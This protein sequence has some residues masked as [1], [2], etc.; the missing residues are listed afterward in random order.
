MHILQASSEVYPF[1]KTGGLADMVGALGKA[2]AAKGE[3]VSMVTPLYASVRKRF[4]ELQEEPEL[5]FKL[6]LGQDT[7]YAGLRSIEVNSRLT[8]YFVDQ[9]YFFDRTG[10][11]Q[12]EGVDYPDNAAR[13]LCFAKTV[14]ELACKLNPPPEIVHCHDWQA[15]PVPLLLLDREQK[16]GRAHV[17]CILT[18]HNLAYQGVFPPE[19]FALTNLS[20]DYFHLDGAEF[21][22]QMNFLKTGLC[23][24]DWITTVSP[25]YAREIMT[26]EFGC[27]LQ[28]VLQMRRNVVTGIL[29]GVDY[30][31]W[32][33][34]KNPCLKHGYSLE[35]LANKG[36]EK[37]NLQKTMGLPLRPDVP[38]FG[39]ISRL[40]E[41]KGF[42][43]Q[44]AALE[45]M[46]PSDMQFVLLGS[47]NREFEK[48]F[49]DLA[50]RF[51]EKIAVRIGYDQELAHQMEAGCDFYVMPSRFEPCGLNQMYSLKYGTI[52]IVRATGGLDDSVRDIRDNPEQANGIK[53]VEYSS[54][55]L[56]LAMRKA[57]EL[58]RSPEWFYLYRYNA[59][60]ADFSW[61]RTSGD[62]LSLYHHVVVGT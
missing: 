48:G 2:L 53:F 4:P 11:Y 33:P 16:T 44:L 8:I 6:K 3:Q 40:V 26:H 50:S 36:D 38:L 32:N 1:S 54:R 42:N 51:S 58:Y 37:A 57:L 61:E 41:Q 56:V 39:T 17:P 28:G 52:P 55:A 10:L 12:E 23:S 62:Y 21:Y 31:E 35:T 19:T 25:R 30:T 15:G 47:G 22:G 24:A 13:F 9:P 34:E 18:V 59:M 46:A 7:F 45:E 29:N 43:I 5:K 49:K 14:V 27:G 20:W 60:A